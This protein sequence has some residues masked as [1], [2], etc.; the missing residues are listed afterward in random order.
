MKSAEDWM[1]TDS[2]LAFLRAQ[3]AS[4]LASSCARVSGVPV[5]TVTGVAGGKAGVLAAPE[6]VVGA[7]ED[8][9]LDDPPQPDIAE[10]AAASARAANGV[11]N[12]R[13]L[14]RMVYLPWM[15]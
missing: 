8:T 4:A 6:R 9:V 7:V 1:A 5:A 14:P 13:I 15:V 3:I 12:I 10:T 11:R 2:T